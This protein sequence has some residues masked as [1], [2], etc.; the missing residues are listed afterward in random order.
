MQEKNILLC[1]LALPLRHKLIAAL[2]GVAISS[3]LFVWSR[4]GTARLPTT[5]EML[6][7][8]VQAQQIDP[9]LSSTKEPAV[10]LGQSILN[11][12]S[13]KGLMK[14]LG[15]HADVAEF[16]SRLEMTQQSPK[17]LNVKY[18]DGDRGLAVAAANAVANVLVGW[19]PPSN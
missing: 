12:D 3:G 13:I 18:Q 17:S 11:D 1:F 10:V 5:A 8:T 6:F 9:S 16:R 4:H 15:I 19:R 7:D 2:I 14:R